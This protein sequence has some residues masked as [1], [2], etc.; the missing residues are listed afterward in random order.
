[1]TDRTVEDLAKAVMVALR[2]GRPDAD[3]TPEQATQVE[4]AYDGIYAEL[5]LLDVAFWAQST[6]PALVWRPIVRMVAQEIAP[7]FGKQYVAG[8][9]LQRIYVAAAKPWSKKRVRALYY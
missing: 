8:D 2:V 7:D 4:D 5:Q 1:M 6:I 3:P 9:A